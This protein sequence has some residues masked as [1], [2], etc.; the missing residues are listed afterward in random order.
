MGTFAERNRRRRDVALLGAALAAIMASVVSLGAFVELAAQAQP[1][2]AQAADA[3][4]SFEVASVKSNKTGDGRVMLGLQPG[5]RFTATNVPLRLLIQNAYRVQGFQVVGAPDWL[6]SE[7][8]DIAAKAEGDPTQEQVQQMV[9]A[10]LADRFKLQVHRETREMPIYVLVMARSDGKLGEKLKP[11]TTDCEAMRGRGRGVPVAPPA[12]GAAMPCGM[13]M[14]PGN[15]LA[16]AMPMTQLATS[17]SNMVG[18]IVVDRTGL[19]GNYDF[20]LTY[21]PEQLAQGGPAG[22]GGAPGGGG[23][24]IDPNGPSIYTAIQEQLGLK[25]DS[26]RGPV[27]TLVIDRVERPTED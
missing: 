14:G 26:Q 17:L 12:P 21:T 13:R 20:E 19:T 2:P 1:Q 16:G 15:I 22:R 7:R 10:L 5:G 11:S 24:A 6:H 3:G 9:R 4:L 8:F 23:P 25:L 18:R 27:E